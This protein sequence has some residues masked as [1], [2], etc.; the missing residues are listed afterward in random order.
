MVGSYGTGFSSGA[1]AG[2]L[3][4]RDM[5]TLAFLRIREQRRNFPDSDAVC[6][7]AEIV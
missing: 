6:D 1:F 2:A 5:M 4:E 7:L 3:R